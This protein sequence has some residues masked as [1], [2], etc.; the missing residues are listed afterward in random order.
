M[1]ANNIL[2]RHNYVSIPNG[3]SSADVSS[4]ATVLMNLSYY[5]Y[6]LD[7]NAY[8]ALLK[9]GQQELIVWWSTIETE[10]KSITG[11]DRKIGDF[12]VYKNFPKEVLDKSEAE[13][14]FAQ[15]L[16][17]W[18]F[19]NE[20]FTEKVE[21]RENMNEQPKLTVLR[22]AGDNSLND[23]FVSYLKQPARWKEHELKDVIFLSDYIPVKLDKLSFK[24]NMV[25]LATRLMGTGK[26]IN[27]T[28]ATDVIRLAAGMSDGD[29]SLRTKFKFRSFKR[30]ER[31]FLLS[32]MENCPHL[33]GDF[34]MR[35]EL[36]KRL[37]H[38]LHPGDYK[39]QYVNVC[40]AAH[41]L[42]KDDLSSF[43][44]S[45]EIAL[46]EKDRKA[47]ELLSSRPGE[48]RRRLVHAI[49][50]FG[51]DAVKA[52][53]NVADN[54]TVAQLVSLRKF[55]ETA[56]ARSHRVFPPKGNWT[57]VQLGE[58]RKIDKRHVT[59]I[60]NAIGKIISERLPSVRLDD[61][62]EM[63]ALPSNDGE[64]SPYNRGTVFPIPDDVTF[65]RTA[66]Y[67]KITSQY[68]N[69]WYDNGWNFF[70][71]RW[72]SVG[73]CCWNNPHFNDNA[74]IFSGDPTNSKEMQGRAAQLIDLYLDKLSN[75]GITYAVWSILGYSHKK[76]S[77]AEDVF[78]ALQWGNSPQEGR[79][80]EPSRCQLSFP[81][82][83]DSLTK[84]ICVINIDERKM[85]YID[86]NLYGNVLS[87]G[88]N[89]SILEKNLPAFME[90]VGSIPTVHDLFRNSVDDESDIHVLYSDK[91][92]ELSEDS[93]AYVFRPESEKN[94]YKVLDINSL[95][96]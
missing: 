83:G 70:D 75:A 91:N 28:T 1:N 29:I 71:A 5:G 53:L 12:V 44:S 8:K 26:T 74:A 96:D 87:A 27:L 25:A 92:V 50:L 11:E 61:D 13:Y 85:T 52:F 45:L 48:F 21:P 93:T 19:P 72:N 65:I 35:P 56:N 76:F 82:T 16:M 30:P 2:L 73:A 89:Q 42:Y 55:V 63:I 59:K 49:D 62:V 15:I 58:P 47:L 69:I 23:I 43:N 20:M 94:Q 38:Q 54:L 67:W 80:F 51:N 88:S 6:S 86:A 40:H 37:I 84:Y 31:K 81:L 32:L 22:K 9:L 3:D 34:A 17:Y 41:K 4:V 24:E 79:L 46:K 18:G 77:G 57:K 36:W 78:A 90:Y 14:W 60:S 95:L 68:H 33:E 7:T 39:K 64:V 66:S 10:L